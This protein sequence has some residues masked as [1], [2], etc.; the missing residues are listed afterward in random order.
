VNSTK[1]AEYDYDTI[2][3]EDGTYNVIGKKYRVIASAGTSSIIYDFA[4]VTQNGAAYSIPFTVHNFFGR[5]MTHSTLEWTPG[6]D[7]SG[8]L[9]G[10]DDC[11]EKEWQEAVDTIF[12]RHG[13]KATFFINGVRPGPFCFNAREKGHEIA[14]HTVNHSNL[15]VLSK[16]E[17]AYETEGAIPAFREQGF[18][19]SSFAYPFGFC[20]KWM[21]RK[22]L[23]RYHVVREFGN[24]FCVY[25]AR[26]LRSGQVIGTKSID[27]LKYA[28]TAAFQKEIRALL[29]MTKFLGDGSVFSLNSHSVSP[30]NGWAI[31]HE[32]LDFVLET[33]RNLKLNFYTYTDFFNPDRRSL[34]RASRPRPLSKLPFL[35]RLIRKI[36]KVWREKCRGFQ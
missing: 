1:R 25:R 7:T 20:E 24:G 4:G 14:S 26:N 21:H 16:K 9:L 29:L 12:A 8:I 35:Y 27:N 2:T 36:R 30:E 23:K 15:R 34:R 19:F 10:F 32:R 17:F 6:E 11:F 18:A 3:K 28:D 13:A 31:S 22:L 5:E 33:A